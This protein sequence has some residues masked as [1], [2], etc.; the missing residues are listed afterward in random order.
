VYAAAVGF[1]GSAAA[2][3]AAAVVVA[4]RLARGRGLER[5]AAH[6]TAQLGTQRPVRLV[7][8]ER[9]LLPALLAGRASAQVDAE[10]VPVGDG[11]QLERLSVRLDPV[12]V[13]LRDTTLHTGAGSFEATVAE[14]ELGDLVRLPGVISRL[15]L[16]AEGLRVWT[17]LGV[18]LDAEVLVHDGA[19]RVLPDPAQTA[20]LLARP[21]LAGLR[22][23]VDG[24]GLLLPLPALP[25]GAVVETVVFDTGRARIAGRIAPQVLPL[26]GGGTGDVPETSSSS[27]GQHPTGS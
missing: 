23:M 2:V 8:P 11:A 15:E 24:L 9:P 19:L 25:F 5:A 21:G 14:R 10:G 26:R 22:R 6:L 27:G 7:V 13:R 12:R 4:E 18:A 17:V 16:R 20:R 1:A 3:P